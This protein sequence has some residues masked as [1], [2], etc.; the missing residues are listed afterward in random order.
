LLGLGDGEREDE[1]LGLL[2][3][4]TDGLKLGLFDELIEGERLGDKL[5][6][7]LT[8]GDI[9]DETEG[10]KLGDLDELILGLKLGDLDAEILGE[11]D[12][13]NEGL[14]L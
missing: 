10:L 9:D 6:D 8:L 11:Y 12:G 14:K 3:D 2:L 13:D 7:G 1:I 4:D 5:A